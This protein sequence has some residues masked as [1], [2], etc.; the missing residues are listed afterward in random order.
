[1]VDNY[2]LH[3]NLQLFAEGGEG[4]DGGAAD[5]GAN[6]GQGVAAPVNRRARRENPL[7]GLKFGRQPE[8][9]PTTQVAAET[10]EETTPARR[11]FEELIAGE[12]KDDYDKAVQNIV[13]KR[14]REEKA[15]QA[16]LDKQLPIL[17]IMA[18]RYGIDSTDPAGI[19]IEALTKALEEDRA[20]YED[21]A[22]REGVPVEV[23]MRSKRL[24][25]QQAAINAEKR[26]AAEQQQMQQEYLTLSNQAVALKSQFPDFDL[27]AE[28]NNAAFGRLVLQP[29]RGVGMSLES[30]YY[31]IHHAEIMSAQQQQ[32]MAFAHQA[33]QA[34]NQ[35]TAN[36]IA[37]GSRRPAENGASSAAPSMIRSDPRTLTKAERAELRRR[38]NAGEKIVW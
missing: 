9:A 13:R 22:Y 21:E 31:A 27:D 20:L 26:A 16:K 11:T 33:V 35:M 29:P 18:E 2:K 28:L 30:A 37:S 8:D 23:L 1:M 4:G 32:R 10:T 25:R 12:Y 17:Q 38:V 14:I 3:L 7:A 6:D 15:A 5:S 34:A 24:D 19:D 36:A